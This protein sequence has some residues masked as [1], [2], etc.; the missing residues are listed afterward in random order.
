[1]AATTKVTTT[2]VSTTPE[3]ATEAPAA[4]ESVS[5]SYVLNTNTMK[6]H[7]ASCSS[8]DQ[9][10]EE[11]TDYTNDYDAAIAAGYVP[12]KRCKP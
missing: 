10:N 12:C 11:N 7:R 2:T 9:M 5:Y 8:V 3:P 1:M 4:D 6:I